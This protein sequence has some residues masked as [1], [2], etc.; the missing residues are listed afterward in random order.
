MGQRL[1]FLSRIHRLPSSI[2]HMRTNLLLAAGAFFLTTIGAELAL[3][4]AGKFEPRKY[5]PENYRPEL[6]T[7]AGK[8]GYALWPSRELTYS[9][10]PA[11]PRLLSVTSNATGFRNERGFSSRDD[12]VRILVVGDSYTFGEGVEESERF[13]N[14]L[15]EFEPDWRV[16]N[17]GMPGY[18]P[19][20]MLFALEEHLPEARPDVVLFSLSYDDFRRVRPRYAGV[21][22]PIP[23]LRLVDGELTRVP[24]PRSALWER[25]HL[26]LL[27][28]RAILPGDGGLF[29][30][31]T[32]E[33]WELNEAI[34]ERFVELAGRH[35]FVPIL[36]YLPG[37]WTGDAQVRRSRWVREFASVHRVHFLDL[38]ASIHGREPG[39]LFLRENSHYNPEGHQVVAVELSSFL[40]E[41]LAD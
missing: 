11:D 2:W 37:P 3:R 23:R 19:D 27:V 15:E 20:L 32:Q 34:L 21:G 40:G 38:S 9:Y 30:V 41:V 6:F 12:R 10:P 35:D 31:L 14:L 4:I 28:R 18:G 25:S 5:P 13:S 17:M 33:E 36:L 24:Y 26:V 29:S 7:S 8:Y 1:N 22:V 39:S 16:D